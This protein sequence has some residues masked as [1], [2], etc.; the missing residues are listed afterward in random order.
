[1]RL[2]IVS[3]ASKYPIVALEYVSKSF[4]E[5]EHSIAQH[6]TNAAFPE[7]SI[8]VRPWNNPQMN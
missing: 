1:M 2:A 8:F 4:A 6:N 7:S 5:I 3:V